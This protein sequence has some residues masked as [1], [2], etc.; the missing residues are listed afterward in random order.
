[1]T[2]HRYPDNWKEIATA[3]KEAAEWK[4]S[5]CHRQCLKPG[6][7]TERSL[8]E[9]IA[10]TLAVHHWNRNPDDNRVENLVA[11]CTGCHLSYHQ[12]GKSNVSPGQLKL[13]EL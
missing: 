1:M 7:K 11:L 12:G 13:F 5:K 10:Y 9:R 2:N 8:S 3:I 6:E 4:C